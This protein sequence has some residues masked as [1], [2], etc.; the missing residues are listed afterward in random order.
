MCVNLINGSLGLVGEIFE[1]RT[2]VDHDLTTVSRVD[3]Q[4][5]LNI[6]LGRHKEMH[7]TS[8]R[9]QYEIIGNVLLA[10]YQYGSDQ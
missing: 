1:V 3:R 6:N 2:Q 9:L 5:G 4:L 8:M 7:P 10:R